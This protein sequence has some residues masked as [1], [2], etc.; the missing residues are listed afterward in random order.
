MIKRKE[1]LIMKTSPTIGVLGLGLFGTSV[2]RTLSK[3][4]VDVLAMDKNMDH[5]EEV[6][7]EV[8]L[9]V[10]GDFTRL[11]QLAD[12]GFGDCDEVVIASAERLE[13]S[14]LAI[15]NLKKLGVPKITVKSKNTTYQ[16][17]LL[18]VGA[19]RVILPEEAMGKEVAMML[20]NPTV[21]ELMKVDSH[22]NI[23]EFP[24]KNSW[25]NQK[26]EEV[27]F[28]QQYELNIIA[29]QHAGSEDF[30]IEFGPDYLIQSGDIFIGITTNLGVQKLK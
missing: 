8:A 28:R 6:I 26:I 2:A 4:N 18:K 17:V 22:Y 12:A 29:I 7:D 15:L 25:V 1:G 16:E 5:L 9:G 23:I 24:T 30:T 19:T 3:N 13:E 20:T 27:H 11:D 21:H 14:I 10:Q